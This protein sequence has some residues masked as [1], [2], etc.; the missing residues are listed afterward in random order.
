MSDLNQ[1]IR[2][3]KESPSEELRKLMA[4][5]IQR[6]EIFQNGPACCFWIGKL[7]D[8][9]DEEFRKGYVEDDFRNYAEINDDLIIGCSRGCVNYRNYR[10]TYLEKLCKE[11]V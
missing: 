11:C 5:I 4:V 1:L 10:K 8:L 9:N 3:Y 2:A 6:Y 7:E